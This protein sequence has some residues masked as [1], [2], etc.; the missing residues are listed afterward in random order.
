LQEEIRKYYA[1]RGIQISPQAPDVISLT[2]NLASILSPLY[3]DI[4][5]TFADPQKKSATLMYKKE[6]CECAKL[7]DMAID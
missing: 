6:H 2:E 3:Q 7:P 4:H 1:G 5:S